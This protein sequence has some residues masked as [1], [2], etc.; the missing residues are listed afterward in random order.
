MIKAEALKKILAASGTLRSQDIADWQG[1]FVLP[2]DLQRFYADVGP[3]DITISN[4]GNAFFLPALSRL[5][6]SQAGFRWN[7]VTG[8]TISDWSDDWLVIAQQEGDPFIYYRPTGAILWAQHGTGH[9]TPTELFSNIRECAAV[10]G[11]L[12][13]ITD[14][15]GDDFLD[16]DCFITPRYRAAA[17]SALT[18]IL[19]APSQAENV[20]TTLEWVDASAFS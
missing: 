19:G 4:Y 18:E 3:D 14:D 16:E 15:A 6:E 2:E 20:L 13:K 12:G 10:L 5:W 8:E 7:G 1:P 17:K 11:T 9:W